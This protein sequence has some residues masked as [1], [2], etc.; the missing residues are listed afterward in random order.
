MVGLCAL[1]HH[2]HSCLSFSPSL[3]P[4]LCFSLSLSLFLT[5]LFLF[6]RTIPRC[7]Q[8]M[9]LPKMG[10]RTHLCISKVSCRWVSAL[11]CVSGV[12]WMS[13]CHWGIS[14]FLHMSPGCPMSIIFWCQ[15]NVNYLPTPNLP[16]CRFNWCFCFIDAESWE[17]GHCQPSSVVSELDIP[18]SVKSMLFQR[19]LGFYSEIIRNWKDQTGGVI[20]G[21]NSERGKNCVFLIIVVTLLLRQLPISS[22]LILLFALNG[23]LADEREWRRGSM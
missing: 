21:I 12:T 11:V 22:F 4:F 10:G 7:Q 1:T 18:H 6:G 16:W 5:Y 15:S 9:P 13:A 8:L 19:R 17:S 20:L 23:P 2:M 3:C 14:S